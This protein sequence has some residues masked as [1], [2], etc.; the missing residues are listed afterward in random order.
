[1]FSYFYHQRIKKCVAVFGTLFNDIYIGRIGTDG[2][3]VSTTKVPL[4]YAPKQKFL[5]RLKE[6][7]DLDND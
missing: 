3:I 2:N 6:N 1:M 7:P 4:S 5:E